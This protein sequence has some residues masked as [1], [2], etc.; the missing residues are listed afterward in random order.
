MKDPQTW[1]GLSTCVE[2]TDVTLYIEPMQAD[3][4]RGPLSVAEG[5][6]TPDDYNILATRMRGAIMPEE[7]RGLTIMSTAYFPPTPHLTPGPGSDC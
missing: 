3:F 5:R 2:L 7:A 1:L 4:R 6:V